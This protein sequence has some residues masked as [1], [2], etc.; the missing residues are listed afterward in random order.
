MDCWCY[1]KLAPSCS[2]VFTCLLPFLLLLMSSIYIERC[3]F[4]AFYVRGLWYL[5][6]LRGCLLMIG[7]VYPEIC[8][9]LVPCL[10][11]V[12]NNGGL[13]DHTSFFSNDLVWF[14]VT[15]VLWSLCMLSVGLHL[16]P[17]RGSLAVWRHGGDILGLQFHLHS[18]SR[19]WTFSV[20]VSRRWL[21]RVH[22]L[23]FRT[24]MLQEACLEA[25]CG[26]NLHF[27][28]FVDC[29]SILKCLP[30]LLT[31]VLYKT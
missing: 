1:W 6:K 13:C 25:K 16:A 10:V 21:C 12:N 31:D 27:D 26:F 7:L 18:L 30:K 8:C 19:R 22:L 3:L 11:K 28:R 24:N 14:R 5:W 23:W 29:T 15:V 20:M 4:I 17:S 9:N 2:F